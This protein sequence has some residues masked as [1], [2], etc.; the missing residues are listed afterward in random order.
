MEYKEHHRLS[1]KFITALDNYVIERNEVND[2][3]YVA[4]R[5]L[6]E[7]SEKAFMDDNCLQITGNWLK[8][9][10]TLN[11]SD[12]MIFTSYKENNLTHFN[13]FCLLD[14]IKK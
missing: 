12:A 14:V 8:G 10:K 1:T 11:L 2:S 13:A 5:L 7:M 3:Y 6:S 4:K 9:G